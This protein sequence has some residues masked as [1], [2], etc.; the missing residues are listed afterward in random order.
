MTERIS[1]RPCVC[2]VFVGHQIGDALLLGGRVNFQ[3]S[4]RM[5]VCVDDNWIELDR[6]GRDLRF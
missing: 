2:E 1:H 4:V 3:I 5:S 6:E